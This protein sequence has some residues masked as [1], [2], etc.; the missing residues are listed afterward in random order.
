MLLGLTAGVARE[1][2]DRALAQLREAGVELDGE[3][4]VGGPPGVAGD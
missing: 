2:T 1:T 3:P 4:Y